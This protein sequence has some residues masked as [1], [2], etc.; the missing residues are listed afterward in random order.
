DGERTAELE[1]FLL[2]PVRALRLRAR[3]HGV[4]YPGEALAA[5]RRAGIGYGGWLANDL[6]PEAFARHRLTVHVPRGPYARSLP[7]I[8]TIRVF[9]ALACG[10]PLV[11][12]PWDDCEGLF[13]P[14]RDFLFA[15]DGAAMT[16]ALRRLL[17]EPSAAAELARNGLETIRARHTC[18]HRVDE[19]L[20]ICAAQGKP[21]TAEDRAA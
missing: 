14:G 4:R 1:T 2:G 16:E 17:A 20:A 13:R 6:V 11:S 5:L 19:L 15:A 3:V 21:G 12:A 10:I 9:E 18:A 7:G 8:P